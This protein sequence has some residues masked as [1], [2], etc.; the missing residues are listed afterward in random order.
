MQ[1]R[2]K[3]LFPHPLRGPTLTEPSGRRFAVKGRKISY[4]QWQFNV[5]IRSSAGP[6]LFDVRYNGTRIAYEIGVHEGASQ[7]SG[8]SPMQTHQ[9][10]DSTFGLGYSNWELVP[11][12]DCPETAVFLDSVH[13]VGA[14]ASMQRKNSICIFE[15]NLQIPLRRH[16]EV[17][18]AGFSSRPKF[19]EGLTDQA[20]V[21]RVISTP[22]NYDYIFDFVFHQSGTIKVSTTASGYVQATH[23]VK[24]EYKYGFLHFPE[25][26][27]TI[28]D[29]YI[30]Y[31]VDLDI[32]GTKNSY[33]TLDVVTKN[34]TN[35]QWEPGTYRMMKTIER[36]TKS[37]EKEAVLHYNFDQPKYLIVHNE[38]AKNRYGNP[39]GYRVQ[40]LL[41]VKQ[42]F[43][44]NYFP[45]KGSPWTK[46]QLAITKQRDNERFGSSI[47][48]QYSLSDPVFDFDSFIRNNENITNQDLVAWL[49]VGGLH[50]PNTEDIP[51]T[52]TAGNSYS[53]YLKPY[54]YFDEDPT[55]GARE[56]VHISK[57][58]DGT[59]QTETFGIPEHSSCPIPDR[60][61]RLTV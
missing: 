20:L 53:F 28:H 51:T 39:R 17:D 23:Y 58:K 26:T 2:G 4:M 61:P 31:K 5:R 30:L 43:P 25:T 44:D 41:M 36:N 45:T 34:L 37:T 57:K 13:F 21:V 8:F 14:H 19:F 42:K 59:Y 24:E 32:A 35:Y 16:R 9:F 52:V 50:I 48:N 47:Y 12:I 10:I 22:Y 11:G 29:H 1:K 60:K 54:G 55:M 38:N 18:G 40:P 46:Y 33:Q 3:P 6:A 15:N 49:T 7:Y 27:G 56:A